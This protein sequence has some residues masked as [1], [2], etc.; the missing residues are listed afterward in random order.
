MPRVTLDTDQS[1]SSSI[2]FIEKSLYHKAIPMFAKVKA[3]F[4]QVI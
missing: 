4:L 2:A 1:T 3:Q